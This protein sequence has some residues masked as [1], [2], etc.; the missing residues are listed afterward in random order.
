MRSER[1][2]TETRQKGLPMRL[3]GGECRLLAGTDGERRRADSNRRWRF[4]RPK[5]PRRKGLQ[6][7]NLSRVPPTFAHHLPTGNRR[8]PPTWPLSWPPGRVCP[9]RSG[10]ASWRWSRPPPPRG[11]GVADE[12]GGVPLRSVRGDHRSRPGPRGR[13]GQRRAPELADR[14]RD[15][16]ALRGP[17]PGVPGQPDG[18][19]GY[20]P[21]PGS[22]GP[23]PSGASTGLSTGS[24]GAWP[25]P[26]LSVQA[27]G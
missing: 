20:A 11:R 4:C 1:V 15:R 18:V 9:S 12:A 19:A 6:G 27:P 17:V 5:P 14:P 3:L 21:D 25:R 10:P 7:H 8:C 2:T 13:P 26:R 23:T 22:A 24:P 16:V